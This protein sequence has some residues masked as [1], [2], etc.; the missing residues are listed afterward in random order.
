M[1]QEDRMIQIAM[2]E[3]VRSTMVEAKAGMDHPAFLSPCHLVNYL[4]CANR[5]FISRQL[6]F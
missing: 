5:C 1:R 4:F 2:A 6:T 3:L